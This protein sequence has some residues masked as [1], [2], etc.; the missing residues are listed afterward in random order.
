MHTIHSFVFLWWE[1][2]L[3]FI[4]ITLLLMYYI[5][6]YIITFSNNNTHSAKTTNIPLGQIYTRFLYNLLSKNEILL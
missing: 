4:K 6:N 2:K 3:K 1:I 5:K